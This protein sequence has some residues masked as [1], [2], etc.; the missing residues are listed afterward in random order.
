[1]SPR[2]ERRAPRAGSTSKF[3]PG[4][5]AIVVDHVTK[6]FRLYN[7]KPMH[8]KD[9]VTRGSKARFEMFRALD[10]ISLT[11]P[12]GTMYGLVGHNGSGK[13]T[14]L[15]MMANIYHPSEGKVISNGRISALLE[16]G[17]GFHPQLSG[18]ENIYLNASIL[19]LGR[20]EIASKIDDI[21]EFAG[22]EDF[23]DTP[24]KVYSSGMYVRL[25]FAVAVNVDPEILLI[26]E[27]I[28]VGDEQFQ[29]RCFDHL[30]SLRKQG[31]TIVMVTHN[32]GLVQTMCDH[33]AW[34]E[35]GVLLSEGKAVAVVKEY[36][37]KVNDQEADEMGEAGG[38]KVG[39]SGRR[40][41]TGEIKVEKVD[42]ISARLTPTPVGN[43]G[44]PLVVR[45]HYNARTP[46]DNP[47]FK[48]GFHHDGGAL[49]GEPNTRLAEFQTGQLEGEGDL[50]YKMPSLPLTPG[51][52]HLSVTV[53]DSHSLHR[54]DHHEREFL[55]HVQ[56]GRSN[57]K[58]GFVDLGGEWTF[59][60][61]TGKAKTG[62]DA[63]RAAGRAD[64]VTEE[65]A[66]G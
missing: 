31:V 37:K 8:L 41:G 18:R 56:P 34:L 44:D 17:A 27:V 43:T 55:L 24:V 57:E 53:L 30:Y 58:S 60:K 5:P 63:A 38:A 39:K 52:Y 28:A 29:R 50:Y 61:H 26:D 16:L 13:S 45:I 65:E 54:F 42:Y 19:G 64:R 2:S 6:D 66:V 49:I 22:L 46:V 23:I 32:M 40:A 21:V 62:L 47:V 10:D 48:L 9:R 59:P 11:I 51:D 4:S 25:G 36:L 15:R 14:L 12:H 7:E 3:E 33:A 35:K 20:R 1:M